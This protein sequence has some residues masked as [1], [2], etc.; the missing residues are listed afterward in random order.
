VSND[1]GYFSPGITLLGGHRMT[2]GVGVHVQLT[3]TP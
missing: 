1:D 2:A 3:G